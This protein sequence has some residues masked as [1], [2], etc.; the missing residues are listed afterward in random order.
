MKKVFYISLLLIFLFVVIPQLIEFIVQYNISKAKPVIKQ[1]APKYIYQVGKKKMVFYFGG[2]NGGKAHNKA[3]FYQGDDYTKVY[4]DLVIN[5][6][7]KARLLNIH[8]DLPDNWKLAEGDIHTM[9]RLDA[10]VNFQSGKDMRRKFQE[11]LDSRFYYSLEDG[12]EYGLKKYVEYFKK[13][14]KRPAGQITHLVTMKDAKTP[15]RLLEVTS[16]TFSGNPAGGIK[17]YFMY[18]DFVQVKV[19]YRKIY[20]KDWQRI[21]NAVRNYVDKLYQEAKND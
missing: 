1:E 18:N 15:L 16:Y 2:I 17:H 10:A 14:N 20:L 21:E 13:D 5:A 12:Y 3:S 11:T 7:G 9:I 8:Y 4:F 6:D 19:S